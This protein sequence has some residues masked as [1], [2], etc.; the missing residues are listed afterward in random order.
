VRDCRTGYQPIPYT[1]Y[2]LS[3]VFAQCVQQQL[4]TT[5]PG[6]QAS[7]LWVAV[8]VCTNDGLSAAAVKRHYN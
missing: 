8:S 7:L 1:T 4:Q 6:A 5:H 2:N 3:C